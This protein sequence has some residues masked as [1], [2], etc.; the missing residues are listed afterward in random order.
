MK[1]EYKNNHL[2]LR[3]LTAEYADAVLSFYRRN[4]EQFDI[5]ETDKPDHFYTKAFIQSLLTAEYNAFV[6]GKHIRFFLF[7]TN[8]P[9]KIIGTV[10]FSDIKKGAF[11][12][13]TTGYK[14]DKEFQHLGYGRRMLTTALKI[15]VTEMHMHRVEAYIAPQ[16]TASISL[17]TK[18]GF[19]PEG[20]AY[21][22]VYLRGKW[23]DHLRFVYIS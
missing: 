16:N 22:Y 15:L 3:V 14:I 19:I 6:A 8:F 2:I 4:R 13:C 5:Y 10:S 20:T 9:D 18:L 21:S 11:C 12:S 1:F 17:A 23:E 7:D